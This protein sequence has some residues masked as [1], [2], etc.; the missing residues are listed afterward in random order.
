METS[1]PASSLGG[2]ETLS[3]TPE[4]AVRALPSRVVPGPGPGVPVG[5]KLV[6]GTRSTYG[7]VQSPYVDKPTAVSELLP[8]LPVAPIGLGA[9]GFLIKSVDVP[10]S[11][12]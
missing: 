4:A 12:V 3:H 5:Q 8:F 7:R 11:T 6:F 10:F 9:C 1:F 2:K